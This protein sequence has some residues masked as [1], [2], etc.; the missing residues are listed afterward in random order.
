MII[1]G[2]PTMPHATARRYGLIAVLVGLLLAGAGCAG[3]KKE[4]ALASPPEPSATESVKAASQSSKQSEPEEK[5]GFFAR[6]NPFR[7]KDKPSD[8]QPREASDGAESEQGDRTGEKVKR[9][10]GFFSRWF[11]PKELPRATPETLEERKVTTAKGEVSPPAFEHNGLKLTLGETSKARILA[12]FG[13][14]ENIFFSEGAE[15]ILIYRGIRKAD[16]L[17]I[18]LDSQGLVKDYIITKRP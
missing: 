2:G 12:T 15:E 8:E 14:P 6:L 5:P 16:S 10:R 17:Y 1:A 7:K 3:K 18:F 11:G 4:A 9:E 13:E